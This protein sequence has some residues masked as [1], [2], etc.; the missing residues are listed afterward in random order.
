MRVTLFVRGLSPPLLSSVGPPKGFPFS[1]AS[2]IPSLLVVPKAMPLVLPLLRRQRR[3]VDRVA[4][5]T[6]SLPNLKNSGRIEKVLAEKKID[7]IY[8]FRRNFGQ[9]LL[10]N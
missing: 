7:F 9:I 5:L 10:F 6:D 4:S 1:T 2:Q 8:C 3:M